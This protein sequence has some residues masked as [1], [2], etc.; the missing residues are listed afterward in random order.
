MDRPEEIERSIATTREALDDKLEAL[1]W[2]VQR[3]HPRNY[4]G[5]IALIVAASGIS[6][7]LAFWWRTRRRQGRFEPPVRAVP[8]AARMQRSV[9]GL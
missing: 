6:L 1:E 2:R 9:A 3:L 8:P 4:A 7:A 5:G